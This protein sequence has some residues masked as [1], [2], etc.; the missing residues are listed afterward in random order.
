MNA[1]AYM[2]DSLVAI[3]YPR[4]GELYRPEDFTVSSIDFDLYGEKN[5]DICIVT[6]GRIFSY[7][8]K[9]IERLK[10]EGINVKIIKLN[11]IKPIDCKAVKI[12]S[13]SKKIFFF[14]ESLVA[15][16]IGESFGYELKKTGKDFFYKIH[17]IKDA[18]VRHETVEQALEEFKLD[19]KGM[20]EVI[21]EYL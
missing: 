14:E 4:G 7:A 18:F 16:G 3:R 17:G 13:E 2:C 20:I 8:C 19:D 10:S 12:A 21:K 11:R 5:A 1:A 15:G 6:Y 9:A